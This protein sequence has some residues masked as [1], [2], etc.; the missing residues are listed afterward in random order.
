MEYVLPSDLSKHLQTSLKTIYNYL[1][2]GHSKIRTTKRDWKTFV[3]FE[4]FNSFYNQGKQSYNW[5]TYPSEEIEVNQDFEPLQKQV[6]KLQY[7][8]QEAE[9]NVTDLS[10]YNSNLQEQ[11]TKYSLLLSEEKNERKE[12]VTNFQ[13]LLQT[14]GQERNQRTKRYYTLAVVT[15]IFGLIILTWTILFFQLD[16]NFKISG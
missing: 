2:K 6:Q 4:D 10:K 15:I 3:H 11:V 5:K 13:N 12:A 1:K 7:D 16:L 9:A 14:V 8:L